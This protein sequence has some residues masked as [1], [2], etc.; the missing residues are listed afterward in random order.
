MSLRLRAPRLSSSK[1]CLPCPALPFPSLPYHDRSGGSLAKGKS[2]VAKLQ[3]SSTGLVR[4]AVRSIAP[5]MWYTALPQL[6]SR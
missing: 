1:L 6:T 4:D 5:Y 3:S 2:E